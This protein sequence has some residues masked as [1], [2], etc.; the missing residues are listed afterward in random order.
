MSVSCREKK[1]YNEEIITDYC[2][3]EAEQIY[4]TEKRYPAVEENKRFSCNANKTTKMIL[5]ML[6]SSHI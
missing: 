5:S 2:G 3:K 4:E 6:R 1:Y